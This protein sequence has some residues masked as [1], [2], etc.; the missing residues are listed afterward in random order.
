MLAADS[1][2]AHDQTVADGVFCVDTGTAH[3]VPGL[4]GVIAELGLTPAHV[5]YVIPPHVHLDHAGGAGALMTLCPNATLIS[6][7][8]APHLI[9]PAKLTAGAIAVY[10]EDAFARDFGALQPVPAARVIAAEDGQT[11]NSRSL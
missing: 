3:T 11:R 4:L 5:D 10:G 1:P 9:D 7:P 2:T 8:S 6:H